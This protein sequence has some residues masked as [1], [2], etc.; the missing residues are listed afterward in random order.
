MIKG[1]WYRSEE[2]S[3]FGRIAN[4]VSQASEVA[5]MTAHFAQFVAQGFNTIFVT[6]PDE[7]SYQG[8]YGGGF[9]YNPVQNPRPDMAAAF[10]LLLTLADKAGLKVVALVGLSGYH[11]L[12][13]DTFGNPNGAWDFIHALVDPSAYYAGAKCFIGDSRIAGWLFDAECVLAN[14]EADIQARHKFIM[15]KYFGFVKNVV[16]WGGATC[17]WAGSYAMAGPDLATAD[18]VA[19]I[20]ALAAYQPEMLGFEAYTNAPFVMPGAYDKMK[21]LFDAVKAAV[22]IPPAQWLLGEVGNNQPDSPSRNRCAMEIVEAAADYGIGGLA[23]WVCD[24]ADEVPD[25]MKDDPGQ[26]AYALN[27]V[28]IANVGDVKLPAPPHGWHWYNPPTPTPSNPYTN[29]K[30]Y[31]VGSQWTTGY[32]AIIYTPNDYGQ[33]V[34]S[35]L[36]NSN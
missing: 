13:D 7:D 31:A 34:I 3:L 6:L 20:S 1:I 16:H 35:A 12:I 11:I 22:S 5:N 9:P 18:A 36:Q 21:A 29:P 27:N 30:S 25:E 10:D 2:G 4:P 8:A 28:A 33:A 32:G 26:Q 24:G 19:R 23:F 15:D 14:Y 17:S